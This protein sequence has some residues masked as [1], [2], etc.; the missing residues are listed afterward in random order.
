M[1]YALFLWGI[2]RFSARIVCDNKS[3]LLL[4]GQESYSS[5]SKH[6]AMRCLGLRDFIIDHVSTKGQAAH[7]LFEELVL[8]GPSKISNVLHFFFSPFSN[9]SS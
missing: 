4:E 5:R 7:L 6:L 9:I 3:A 8:V 2:N 1:E